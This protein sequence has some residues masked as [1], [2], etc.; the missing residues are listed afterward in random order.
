[1]LDCMHPN[2]RTSMVRQLDHHHHDDRPIGWFRDEQGRII[3]AIVVKQ[4]T[5][6]RIV[7]EDMADLYHRRYTIHSSYFNQS[8][9][10]HGMA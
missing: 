5:K 4:A 6:D 8:P 7:V 3:S 9:V 1:M 10:L 2:D